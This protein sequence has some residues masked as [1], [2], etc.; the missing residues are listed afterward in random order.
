MGG[1]GGGGRRR[2]G[3]GVEV[4]ETSRWNSLLISIDY[5]KSLKSFPTKFLNEE[6]IRTAAEERNGTSLKYLRLTGCGTPAQGSNRDRQ[7]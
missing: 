5:F 6:E 4:P 3:G 7:D 1:G 2:R